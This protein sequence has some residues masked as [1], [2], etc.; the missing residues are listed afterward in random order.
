M[1][2]S[3]PQLM[4]DP[5]VETYKV[6]PTQS[7][8]QLFVNIVSS[9]NRAALRQS[10]REHWLAK[11]DQVKEYSTIPSMLRAY[12]YFYGRIKHSVETDD[13]LDDLDEAPEAA[14]AEDVTTDDETPLE[15]K[16]DAIWQSLL[17][18][19]K[20]VE[21]VLDEGDD[22]QVIFETLNDRGEPL[23]AA[24]L[25]R[26]N[27]FQRADARGEDAESLFKSTGNPSRTD[28]G[29][30]W[31]NR[32]A[33][34]ATYRVFLANFIAGKI[35]GEVTISKLFSEYKAFLRSARNSTTPRY[36]TV[37]PRFRTWSVTGKSTGRSLSARRAHH[38]PYFQPGCVL[39]T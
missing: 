28:S 14:G 13:L 7:N 17:E 9:E 11:R 3:D 33:T 39:G 36:A 10:Y 26:N 29:V 15:L 19:F 24:D 6:W 30:L 12:D 27:I 38:S 5:E 21:I 16:L 25:V 1:L 2:N 32:D 18:E 31:K 8:R 35:A 37:L 20:V 22:A 34:K 4:E 23:L